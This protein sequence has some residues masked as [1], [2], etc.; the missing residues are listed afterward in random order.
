MFLCNAWYVA[1]FI[2][3]VGRE[4]LARTLL[5][6]KVVLFRTEAGNPVALEDRCCHRALPLSLGQCVGDNLQC[7]YHGLQFDRNRQCV[8]V[9]G[10]V[11]IPPNAAVRS[12]PLVER[13]NW[14]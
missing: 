2:G 11:N 7:G 5:N 10:Q 13:W 9:P 3:E 12:Y 6:D 14:I 1:A 8:E 4:S